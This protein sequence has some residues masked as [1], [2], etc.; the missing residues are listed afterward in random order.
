MGPMSRGTFLAQQIPS[1]PGYA[2]C[3]HCERE[4]QWRLYNVIPALADNRIG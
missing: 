1:G 3:I 2:R 4:L